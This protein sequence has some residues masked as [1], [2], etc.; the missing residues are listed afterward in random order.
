[1]GFR[2]PWGTTYPSNLRIYMEKYSEEE[3]VAIAKV[4][5]TRPPMPWYEIRR[6][7]EEDM[8]AVYRF[9]RSLGPAGDPAPNYVPPTSEP[10]TPY[11]VFVPQGLPE[12]VPAAK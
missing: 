7:S 3:W 5:Q 4:I 1:M 9:I 10:A 2:G 8:R 11:I 12:A 6:W